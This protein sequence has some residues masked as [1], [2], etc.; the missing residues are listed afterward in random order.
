MKQ[1]SKQFSYIDCHF[2]SN[3]SKIN[4][5]SLL[6]NLQ[7]SAAYHAYYTGCIRYIYKQQSLQDKLMQLFY[8]RQ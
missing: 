8:C 3:Y 2:H 7:K 1:I 6:K 5:I 4:N